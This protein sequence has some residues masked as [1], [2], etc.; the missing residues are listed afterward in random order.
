M[1]TKY[2]AKSLYDIQTTCWKFQ[3]NKN[4][5][6]SSKFYYHKHQIFI[7]LFIKKKKNVDFP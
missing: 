7:H 1:H 4:N 3:Y 6:Y 2:D 5:M